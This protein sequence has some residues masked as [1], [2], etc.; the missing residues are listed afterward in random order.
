MSVEDEAAALPLLLLAGLG[1]HRAPRPPHARP[2]AEIASIEDAHLLPLPRPVVTGD[3]GVA[4]AI[5]VAVDP[6]RLHLR[7]VDHL[8]EAP[9]RGGRLSESFHVSESGYH[10][11]IIKL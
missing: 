3:Q 4:A 9:R 1:P 11:E 6:L 2:L 5:V 8:Q 10:N 7:L